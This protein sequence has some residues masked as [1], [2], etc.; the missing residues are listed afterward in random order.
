M[1]D[2]NNP[3]ETRDTYNSLIYI[4]IMNK[5]TFMFMLANYLGEIM[6]TKAS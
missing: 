1:A 6:S 3:T 4:D 5:G 2:D